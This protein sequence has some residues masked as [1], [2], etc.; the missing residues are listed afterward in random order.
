MSQVNDNDGIRI[1]I[2]SMQLA[3]ILERESLSQTEMLSNR[4]W[5]G[6]RVVGGVL[7]LVGA[8]ALCV[9]P[10]PTMASKAGCFIFGLHGSDT[11][12]AGV[13]Q[14]WTGHDT[15]TLTH[16]G[17]T[18][19]ALKLGVDPA[20]A[21]NIGLSV[22]IAVPFGVASMLG[23]ARLSAIRAGRIHLMEHEA[24]SLKGPGGHTLQKHV[25]RTEE[26]LRAR[27]AE[28][29]SRL[30]VSSFTNVRTA[31]NAISKVIQVNQAQI[32]TWASLPS[33]R[34]L[35][36]K[37]DINGDIGYGV[38]RTTGQ[39]VKLR[40]VVVRFKYETYNGKPYYILTSFLE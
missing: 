30:V 27:L 14:I 38:I 5:G 10:E 20:T 25:G 12:T 36:L 32:K 28:E 2:S 17:I 19:L 18:K 11:V 34:F 33:P 1:A 7:E 9:V 3:T 31:E 22:D 8:G 6:L 16:K 26:Q 15:Q 40:R 24:T 4:F 23:T 39:L 29:P 21:G 35:T 37:Q 13:K